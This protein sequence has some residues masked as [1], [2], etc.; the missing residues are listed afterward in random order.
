V[1]FRSCY[2]G[3]LI[4]E[5]PRP[6]GPGRVIF[7]EGLEPAVAVE[8][9][10]IAR[11]RGWHIQGYR[12]DQLICDRD[13]AETHLYARIAGVPIVFVDDL[14]ESVSNGTIKLVCVS[15]D[16]AVVDACIAEL[17]DRLRG[18]VRVTRSLE[19]FVEV[20]SPR[21]NKAR[22]VET[23]CASLGLRLRDAVAVGD[24]ANDSEMLAAAGCGVVV[25]GAR[26]EVIAAADATCAGPD[27]AG[28]ADVLGHFGLT[29]SRP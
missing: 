20:V 8:A 29:G 14:A 7:E 18:R 4:Q 16:P 28:V 12:D 11:E 15:S 9:V 2:Q 22:A 23:V 25:R 27:E 24:A 5:M 3:A 6:Q 10:Q 26:P 13:T 21:V 19:Q 17:T 1:L